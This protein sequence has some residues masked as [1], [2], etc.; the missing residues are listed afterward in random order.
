M[1]LGR[2]RFLGVGFLVLGPADDDPLVFRGHI[3]LGDI[4]WILLWFPFVL[5]D[6]LL[7]L[8]MQYKKRKFLF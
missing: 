4:D 3:R 7:G 8:M 1:R 2:R 5:L 6:L